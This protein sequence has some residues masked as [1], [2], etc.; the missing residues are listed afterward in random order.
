MFTKALMTIFAATSL[1]TSAQADVVTEYAA[2]LTSGRF[3]PGHVAG[4]V[5]DGGRIVMNDEA[6]TLKLT[7]AVR[8]IC[9]P[10]MAC[11][12]EV[13]E[14]LVVELPIV[15]ESKD[16]CGGTTIIASEDLRPVDGMLREIR[17]HISGPSRCFVALQG[18]TV[19]YHTAFYN[20]MQGNELKADSFFRGGDLK[21]VLAATPIGG[22]FQRNNLLLRKEVSIG[23]QNAKGLISQGNHR[24]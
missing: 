19:T 4:G 5:F 11:T 1:I 7:A 16:P 20:R 13:P 9:P 18:V 17:L 10:G 12:L 6:R 21:P 3:S 8:K 14:P 24:R 23:L 2:S 22:A 15:E